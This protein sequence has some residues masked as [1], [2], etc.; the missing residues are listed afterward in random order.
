MNKKYVILLSVLVIL[1]FA[2]CSQQ[3]PAAALMASATPLSPTAEPTATATATAVLP[4]AAP[5]QPPPSPTVQPS[6]T[7]TLPAPS[8]T[9]TAASLTAPTPTPTATASA[10]ADSG[11]CKDEAAFYDDVTVPDGTNFRQNTSFVKTWRLKNTGT[12]A[13][14]SDYKFVYAGGDQLNGPQSLPLPAVQPGGIFDM[15]VNLTSPANGGAYTGLW[16]F[17]RPDGSRFGVNSNGV[18][19]IWVKIAVSYIVVGDTQSGSGSTTTASTSTTSTSTSSSTG[20]CAPPP[21][22]NIISQLLAL[23]NGARAAAGLPA[24]SLS[25]KLSSAAQV[26]SQDMACNSFM[27]HT[28]SDGST[29]YVRIKNQGYDYS[30]ASE[31]I[32]A[33]SPGYGGDAQGA[34][35]WWMNSRVHHD[36]IMSSKVTEIG[37]G[38]AY[39]QGSTYGGYFTLDFARPKIK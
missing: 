37:I 13:W 1:V 23:L 10:S 31:N 22:G 29:W 7:N 5:T 6:P 34:Y 16:E 8:P 27:D 21:D 25:G 30:Y 39:N 35:T 18:D 32:Y 28:G 24:L 26:H 36:N 12:C 9:P 14:G 20:G 38:Y 15:S 33:A 2:A 3:K 19:L 17:Q 11:A 4:T